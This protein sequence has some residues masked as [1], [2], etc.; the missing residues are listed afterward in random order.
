MEDNAVKKAL[1]KVGWINRIVIRSK[2]REKRVSYG[3]ENPRKTF[4]VI[5]RNAPNAGLYSF[6]LTNLGWMKYAVDK[7]YIPV[8]DMQS[9]YNTYLTHEQ[10]GQVKAWK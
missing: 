8:V 3:N 1:Q 7:G 9:F 2:E 5:R 10:V 4:F 6:V